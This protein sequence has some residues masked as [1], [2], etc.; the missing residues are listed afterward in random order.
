MRAK[1]I[2]KRAIRTIREILL[3][4]ENPLEKRQRLL[5]KRNVMDKVLEMEFQCRMKAIKDRN[6]VNLIKNYY[7][8]KVTDEAYEV[9]GLLI[10]ERQ[11]FDLALERM[12]IDKKA[13]RID[14]LFNLVEG[15]NCAKK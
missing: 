5:K 14:E 3:E 2:V 13:G 10:G 9:D 4:E 12:S 7:M 6:M 11:A 1:K 8:P 15:G